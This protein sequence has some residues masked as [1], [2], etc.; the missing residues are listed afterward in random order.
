MTDRSLGGADE[1][2]LAIETRHY[3]IVANRT[4]A[5]LPL[6]EAA[7][8]RAAT[9]PARFFV[10]VPIMLPSM[11]TAAMLADPVSGCTF[12]EAMN[13]LEHDCLETASARLDDA[14]N[15]L[16]VIGASASGAVVRAEPFTAALDAVR[17]ARFDEI[18]VSTLPSSVSK[19]LHVDLPRRLARHTR[20]PVTHIEH[21]RTSLFALR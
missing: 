6:M 20:L 15:Y 12:P 13:Q 4:L 17:S 16:A 10:L 2:D 21:D 11:T 5:G 1:Q 18:L 14:L 8:R 9:S 3:L 7:A 19:W